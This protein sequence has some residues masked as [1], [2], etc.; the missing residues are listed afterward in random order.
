MQFG[1]YC[2]V[3]CNCNSESVEYNAVA[4]FAVVSMLLF[5]HFEEDKKFLLVT[6]LLQVYFSGV[7]AMIFFLP[8]LL[9]IFLYRSVSQCT[10]PHITDYVK[11]GKSVQTKIKIDR[12]LIENIVEKLRRFLHMIVMAGV[13]HILDFQ[14]IGP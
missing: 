11:L 4:E 9:F 1:V 13:N 10:H 12:Q 5:S 7:A 3:N 6:Y 8:L 14:R 2:K